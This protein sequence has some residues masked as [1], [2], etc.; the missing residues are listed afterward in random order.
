[1]QACFNIQKSIKVV[2]HIERLKRKKIKPRDA[3]NIFDKIHISATYLIRNR[4]KFPSI[5]PSSVRL[6][7]AWYAGLPFTIFATRYKST[8]ISKFKTSITKKIL[9]E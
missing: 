4:R 1:M 7:Y 2:H 9:S 5:L 6:L 8:V 3:E